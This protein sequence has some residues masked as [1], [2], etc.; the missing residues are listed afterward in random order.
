[1][2]RKQPVRAKGKERS[3]G[4][5]RSAGRTEPPE[6]LRDPR[7]LGGPDAAALALVCASLLL[8]PLWAAGFSA[9]VRSLQ[10]AAGPD[11]L[12]EMLGLPLCLVLLACAALIAVWREW[13]GGSQRY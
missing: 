1:M 7:A 5:G 3:R 2:K 11:T 8:A 6:A 10:T 4:N 9:P 12:R 13:Q